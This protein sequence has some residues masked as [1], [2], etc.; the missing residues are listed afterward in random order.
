MFG[1]DWNDP[2]TMAT[3]NMAAGLL[4]GGNFGQ[5]LGRGLQGYSGT[6]A[7]AEDRAGR[8]E[9]RAARKLLADMQMEQL[10]AAQ[11][12][13]QGQEDWRR[14]L[15]AMLNRQTM[16]PNDAGP[17][18]GPDT[19]ALNQYLLD[20]NSPF[21]DKLL[22]RQLFPK[23]EEAFT[24][25]EGQVRFKGNQVVAQGPEKKPD[26]PSAVREYEYARTQGYNK[27]FEQFQI[28]QRR[29]GAAGGVTVKLPAFESEQQKARGKGWG[30]MF[31]QINTSAFRAPSIMGNLNRMEQLLE[32]LDGGKLARTG[33][34]IASAAKSFGINLDPKLGN[35]QAAESLA[36]EMALSQREPGSGPMTDKDFDNYLAIV[37]DLAK[38]PAGRKQITATM[39]AKAERDVQIAKMAREYARSNGGN[40]DDNFLDMVADYV[41]KNPV[42][43]A[44]NADLFNR[45]DQIIKGR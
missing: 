28:D 45:A 21:A 40:L 6:M 29:A 11:R 17:T 37:P 4:G 24:L 2:K 38:T 36:I 3:L 12:K 18:A 44:P 16:I 30:E 27:S 31:N 32:G 1:T 5:A 23:E 43:S 19:E 25:G 7:D 26:L 33:M 35:K 14:N 10:L 22:E 13:Q 9:D 20:P 15:P 8:K 34:E 39:R 41:A 42:F